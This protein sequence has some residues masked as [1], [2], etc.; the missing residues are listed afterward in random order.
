[1]SWSRRSPG[2][3]LAIASG[4]H[5]APSCCARGSPWPVPWAAVRPTWVPTCPVNPCCGAGTT[6][7]PT[8]SATRQRA[9]YDSH[10]GPRRYRCC[11]PR[12]ARSIGPRSGP[13]RTSRRRQAAPGDRP[14]G[15]PTRARFTSKWAT[16]AP[17]RAGTA[18]PPAY[19][20]RLI[21]G[22]PRALPLSLCAADTPAATGRVPCPAY[23][24]RS[25]NTQKGYRLFIWRSLSCCSPGG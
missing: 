2:A 9:R 10:P 12:Q 13:A 6:T 15:A 19:G 21:P 8:V 18:T 20:S 23:G 7:V 11:T 14:P 4:S 5:S 16:D 17:G 3:R 1:M 22:A 24:A 25:R